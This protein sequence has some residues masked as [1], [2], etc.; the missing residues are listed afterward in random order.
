MARSAPADPG[1][2]DRPEADFGLLGPFVAT[3]ADRPIEV[4]GI[5]RSVLALLL[6]SPGRAVS[7]EEMISGLWD[8]EPPA[9]AQKAVRSYIARLRRGLADHPHAAA[10]V[11]TRPRGYLLDVTS[12]SVDAVRF[13]D[14]VRRARTALGADS[15]LDARSLLADGLRLWRGQAYE[16]FP[17][18]PFAARARSRLDLLR[19]DAIELRFDADVALGA[20]AE[21]VA[22]LE[23]LVG[24]HPHR[25][26]LWEH[27]I[28]ALY[29]SGRQSDAL[30]AY[31]RAR[32]I[33][34]EQVG[35]EPGPGLRRVEQ[36][37]LEQDPRLDAPPAREQPRPAAV[38]APAAAPSAADERRSGRRWP[39]AVGAL[40]VVGAAGLTWGL[41]TA[42]PSAGHGL[43]A[44][45][46]AIPVGAGPAEVAFT[47][48]GTRAYV[49]N[50]GA[51]TVTVIDTATAAPIGAPI[52][53][54]A[55]PN[56]VVFTPDGS[57]AYVTNDE[58]KDVSVIDTAAGAVVATIPAGEW[59]DGLA[60]SPDGG[61]IFVANSKGD[62]IQ[63]NDAVTGALIGPPVPTAGSTPRSLAVSP[64]GRQL[65]VTNRDAASVSMIELDGFTIV[66]DPIPVGEGPVGI[67]VSPDG[68]F[69][70]VSNKESNT[71]VVIDAVARVVVG[72]AIPV[73]L[74]PQGITVSPDGR[75][76]YVSNTESDTVSVIDTESRTVAGEQI[77]VGDGPSAVAVD[78]RGDELYVVNGLS[79]TVSVLD[80]P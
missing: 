22:E 5:A 37:V 34:I 26:R 36:A 33:L 18:V 55:K 74:E 9:G 23:S 49:T 6:T 25:E 68:R 40:A 72:A 7:I 27:L 35:V 66:G 63:Q 11:A 64:D 44:V 56:G 60:I 32:Q 12:D 3:V 2:T 80:L 8:G 29:R 17:D 54:G 15:P 69:V 42:P 78:P 75:R 1:P 67:V 59:P 57:R 13:E 46:A 14:H 28:V 47:P 30:G 16:D 79:N 71:V 19:M 73:G 41:L 45:R 24:E 31:R 21:L 70:Y 39:L 38:P 65:W 48:D 52:R 53:V 4:A 76:V 51:N 61:R 77:P 43:P 10:L 62:T 58:S 50:L 20:G